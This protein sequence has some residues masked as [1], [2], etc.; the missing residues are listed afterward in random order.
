MAVALHVLVAGTA[1]FL[2]KEGTAS[3]IWIN[4][5]TSPS[6][7]SWSGLGTFFNGGDRRGRFFSGSPVAAPGGAPER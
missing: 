3:G 1:F 5:V 4:A 2:I 6:G 7:K